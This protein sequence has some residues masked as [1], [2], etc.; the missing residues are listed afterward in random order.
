M[1]YNVGKNDAEKI[2]QE[3]ENLKKIKR[4]EF[5]QK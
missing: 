3:L 2:K 4:E 5:L 1:E